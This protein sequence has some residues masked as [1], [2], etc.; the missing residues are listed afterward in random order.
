MQAQ[1]RRGARPIPAAAGGT[2]DA[3][4]LS[5]APDERSAQQGQRAWALCAR[6]PRTEPARDKSVRQSVLIRAIEPW[7]GP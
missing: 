3:R 1:R 5:I 4:V 7:I 6:L 2:E